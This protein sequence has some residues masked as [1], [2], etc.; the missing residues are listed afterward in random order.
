MSKNCKYAKWMPHNWLCL[1]GLCVLFIVLFYLTL[2]F[3][4]YQ[5]IQIIRHPLITGSQ[6]VLALILGTLSNLGVAVALLTVAKICNALKKIKQA[7]APCCCGQENTPEG[8]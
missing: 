1:K 2:V 3:A 7:V 5:D 8:K 6:K 4:V